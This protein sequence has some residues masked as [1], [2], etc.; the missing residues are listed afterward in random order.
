M[1][2]PKV[3][4]IVPVYNV[5]KYLDH[6]IQS[7]LKQTLKEIEIILVDDESPDKCAKICDEYATKDPRVKVIHKK[8]EGLGLACNSGLDMAMGEYVAFCD[9]DDYVDYEMYEKM[10]EAAREYK[11]EVVFTGIQSVNEKG[12]V[13]PISQAKELI[14][15]NTKE[16][17][18]N[19]LLDMIASEPGVTEERMVQMSAK[20]VLYSRHLLTSCNI[21]FVSER[22]FISEDLIFH[23]DVL[24]HAT[25]LCVLPNTFYYYYNNTSSLSKKIRT[26]RFP[27][28]I[29]LRKEVIRRSKALGISNEVCTRSNRMFI[30]Y[31]RFYIQQICKSD[32]SFA[33]KRS[34]VNSICRNDIWNEIWRSYPINRMPMMHK[35][36]IYLMRYN[37]FEIIFLIIKLKK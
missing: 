6:C 36:F 16:T 4:I 26:D 23:I 3:S 28:F 34:L 5:E 8:N 2:R 31:V 33:E 1:L 14:I 24:G 19:Y 25:S 15:L 17:I 35:L 12:I 20:I 27:F 37:L 9:S 11:T 13:C 32:I 7:L 18:N 22:K 29:A 10:Y 21:H 30:G